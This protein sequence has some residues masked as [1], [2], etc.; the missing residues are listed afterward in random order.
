MGWLVFLGVVIVVIVVIVKV[1]RILAEREKKRNCPYY[2]TCV[3]HVGD[4]TDDLLAQINVGTLLP[5]TARNVF[6]TNMCQG[7]GEPRQWEYCTSYIARMYPEN[8]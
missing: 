6:I 4:V 5:M 2:G 3:S 8:E 7:K 1:R